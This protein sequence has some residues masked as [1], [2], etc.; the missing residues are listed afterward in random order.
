MRQSTVTF[1]CNKDEFPE[2]RVRDLRDGKNPHFISISFTGQDGVMDTAFHVHTP[3]Q[4]MNFMDSV[5]I[6]CAEFFR[7]EA[8]K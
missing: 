7:K 4:V 3:K 1:S 2:C 8:T 6:A 5:A